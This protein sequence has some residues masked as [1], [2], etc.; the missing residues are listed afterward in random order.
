MG[1]FGGLFKGIGKA[2]FGSSD[3]IKWADPRRMIAPA[4]PQEK[5]L[6]DSLYPYAKSSL[7]RANTLGNLA[8]NSGLL[9]QALNNHRWLF[10]QTL[11]TFN[12]TLGQ[13]NR[14]SHGELPASYK[15]AVNSMFKTQFGDILNQTAKRGIVNSSITQRAINDALQKAVDTEVK[16]LPLAAE[17]AKQPL[18]VAMS[19]YNFGIS[20][21]LGL[22]GS[23]REFEKDYLS[24]PANLWNTMM[25]A[26]HGVVAQ[27][28]VKKGKPG[29]LGALGT[30]G[31]AAVGAYFGGPVGALMGAQTGGLLGNSIATTFR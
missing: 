5:G 18:G 16:Y 22:F 27:P 3:K 30:L 28:I 13:L 20:Q 6:L 12:N 21:L 23:M 31:G 9:G 25:T 17:L 26:R 7:S 4:S 2:L 19:K 24:Y 10:G 14:I 29:L 1:L 15:R 8:W 11:G